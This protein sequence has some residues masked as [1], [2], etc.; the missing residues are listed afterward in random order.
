MNK[1][2]IIVLLLLVFVLTSLLAI[3]YEDKYWALIRFFFKFFQADKIKFVGKYVYFFPHPYSYIA[4]GVF[5][6]L[7][8]MLLYRQNKKGRF[9]YLGLAIILFFFITTIVTTYIDS[10]GKV[11]ECTA[12]P[13]G[14]RSLHYNE[15]DYDFHFITSLVMGLLPLLWVFL[16]KQMSKRRQRK[17]GDFESLGRL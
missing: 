7:F 8:M 9:I 10:L 13:D 2:K 16:K 3:Y 11:A 5:S 12:C 14:V 1:I 15:V 6:V 4:F 17:A